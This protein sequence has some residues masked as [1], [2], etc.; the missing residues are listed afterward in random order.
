MASVNKAILIGNLGRDPELKYTPDGTAICTFAIATS[1]TWNDKDGN[2][3]EKTDWHN[4]K[5]FRRQAEVANEYLKKGRP[6]YIEGR[7]E[8][9]SW[10]QDGQK[11][12]MTEIIAE[13]MQFLG[14]RRDE[15]EAGQA[16]APSGD[17][18]PQSS[19][20]ADSGGEIDSGEDLPF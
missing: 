13:K 6:V 10:E 1:R 19:S 9:R 11:R 8:T 12:Y 7:I 20:P 5:L 14:S 3:Q 4:I 15:G 2:R 16:G 18:P 17:A